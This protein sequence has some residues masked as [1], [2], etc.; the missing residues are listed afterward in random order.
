[1]E[2]GDVVVV[3]KIVTFLVVKI[4]KKHVR[5]VRNMQILSDRITKAGNK[6]FVHEPRHACHLYFTMISGYFT[7][8]SGYWPLQSNRT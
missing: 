4:L 5:N 1:M 8:I 7:M 3:D 2:I 6:K